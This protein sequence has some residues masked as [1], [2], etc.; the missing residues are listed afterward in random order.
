MSKQLLTGTLEEQ[1]DILVQIAQE[2]MS[3]GN[4]TGAY[5]ALKEVVKHAP[6][7][8][9]AAALL[10]VAKQRKSEQTRLLLISLAG[11][12]LFV[13][14]GSATRLFGDPW[15]LVLGFVGLL[16][17]YGVGN[18]LNSLRRPAKPEMK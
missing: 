7:R 12:I 2:K 1:C 11:A 3:T 15:L 16:V 4:Y 17:G 6:D 13:G 10:A 8:Q 5:H 14:I 18:L 9:D